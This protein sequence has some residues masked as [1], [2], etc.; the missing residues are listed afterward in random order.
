LDRKKSRSSASPASTIPVSAETGITGKESLSPGGVVTGSVRT[1]SESGFSFGVFRLEADGTLFRED[2]PV[3]LPPRELA[4][5]QFLLVHAGQIVTPLQLKQALW[6]DVHVTADSV[7]KCL[8]SLRAKLEPEECIQTV[9][10]RGYRFS[11]EV[12]PQ[13]SA[14]AASLPRLAITPFAVLFGVSEHLGQ[15]V[16]E[17]TIARLTRARHPSVSILA[18]DSVFTLALRGLSAQQIGETLN[19][20]LVITGTLRAL[21]SHFRLRAEMILVREGTQIWVEDL[22]VDRS[23]FAGLESELV[24]R[25]AF[26]LFAA[27]VV[28]AGFRGS[29]EAA[30]VSWM[31]SDL[32]SQL[33][34]H[35]HA[36]P[37]PTTPGS[38]T[39]PGARFQEASP[40]EWNS[41]GLSIS[42]A[43]E[44]F[45]ERRKRT[46]RREAYEIYQRGHHEWQTLQRHRMQDG[47]QLLTRAIE[48]DPSLI[49]ARVDLVNLCIAQSFYGFMPPT[50]AADL[51]RR[52]A[53]LGPTAAGIPGKRSLLSGETTVG[54]GRWGESPI[55]ELPP[56]AEAILPAL[57]WI[58]FH[59]DYDLPAALHAFSV[60]AHLPHDPSITRLRVMFALSRHHFD[61]AIG[62]LRNAL[63]LDPYSPSLHARLA[64]AHHLAS[65]TDE[66]VECA[67]RTLALFPEDEN[68]LFYGAMILAFNGDA[69][70]AIELAQS[71]GHRS[72]DFDIASAVHAYALACAG[73]DDEARSILERL[74]W[75]SRER[76]VL[77][78][79]TPAVHV[80]LGNHNA[81]LAELQSDA[82]ARC[83]WF[84]QMLADPRL[85]PL[86][87]RPEFIELRSILTRME[88]AAESPDS[89]F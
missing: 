2:K 15:A 74:Q 68:S 43:A 31:A 49:A 83:P 81:A 78:S 32:P 38:P 8:S 45:V 26:R 33:A 69:K 61:E 37:R 62:L 19:A 5:L 23:R 75:L 77:S 14:Q 13:G 18:R 52:T 40:Q 29:Q 46:G 89:E 1:D 48:L 63:Q 25:L 39:I 44:P 54:L 36:P 24:N 50:V 12:R 11:A 22:L 41:P 47:L 71:L 59:V 57:G 64:W 82:D 7:P 53:A 16:A 34:T 3:H 85:S 42:A 65:Q 30:P 76:F 88:E 6:G 80:V 56:G 60:T 72:P 70:H 84:F 87:S 9:Y 4:A 55:P 27:G 67:R 58:S 66:S 79:F 51:V 28:G 35:R 10:K 21:P 73:R 17:E 20:D 86:H